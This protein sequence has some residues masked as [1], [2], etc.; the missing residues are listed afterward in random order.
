MKARDGISIVFV[1]NAII[2]FGLILCA[3]N[4]ND[5]RRELDKYAYG[6][7]ADGYF[8]VCNESK[9]AVYNGI[10]AIVYFDRPDKLQ[11]GMFDIP[12]VVK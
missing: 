11:S 6:F 12:A 2:A 7:D 3:W 1:V 9:C 8:V 5:K 10:E 4:F